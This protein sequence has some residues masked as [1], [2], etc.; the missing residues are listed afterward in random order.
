[1]ILDNTFVQPATSASKADRQNGNETPTSSRN[2]DQ[3]DEPIRAGYKYVIVWCIYCIH[4]N[5]LYRVRRKG[6]AAV[7]ILTSSDNGGKENGDRQST[8]MLRDIKL[9]YA[10]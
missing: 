10:T 7:D 2:S 4:S 9:N 6:Q 1:V 3:S 5:V 8:S